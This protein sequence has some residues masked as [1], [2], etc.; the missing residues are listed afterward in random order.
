MNNCKIQNIFSRDSYLLNLL[1]FKFL[2]TTVT[3]TVSLDP[4]FISH[5]TTTICLKSAVGSLTNLAPRRVLR[6]SHKVSDVAPLGALP[7]SN[8]ADTL[9]H[10]SPK[11]A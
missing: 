6:A 1:H 4:V 10:C 9:A 8:K 2:L 7:V 11:A 3:S 5:K